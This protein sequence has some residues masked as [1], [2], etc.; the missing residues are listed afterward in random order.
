MEPA[1]TGGAAVVEAGVTED[2]LLEA[3]VDV[4]DAGA[5]VVG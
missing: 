2:V 3:A 5:D 1:L 4:L